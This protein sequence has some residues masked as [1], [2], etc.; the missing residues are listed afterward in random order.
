MSKDYDDFSRAVSAAAAAKRA[1][2]NFA[3]TQKDGV[4]FCPRCG[5]FTV[6]DR[7]HT[8]ALSRHASVYIC[9]ACGMDEAVREYAGTPLHLKDWAV[10][11]TGGGGQEIRADSDH[12]RIA[13]HIGTWHVIDEAWYALTPDT[14]DGP[15]T[16]YAHCFLLEHEKYGDEAPGLIV[17]QTGALLLDD[18]YNGFDDLEESGWSAVSEREYQAAVSGTE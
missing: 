15:A 4:H 2:D 18:V 5:R 9:D 11:K 17:D 12:I 14:P 6:K 13:G 16:L 8:N 3:A 7:L 1:L 10:A